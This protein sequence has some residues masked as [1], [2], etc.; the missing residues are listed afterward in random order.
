VSLAPLAPHGDMYMPRSLRLVLPAT[1]ALASVLLAAPVGAQDVT[2]SA[3]PS[4]TPTSAPQAAGTA[5]AL[6]PPQATPNPVAFETPTGDGTGVRLTTDLGDVVIG[7]FTESAPVASENFLNLVESGYYDGVGFHRVVPGF[8]IQGGDPEGTGAGGPGY[9]IADEEVVGEYGRGIVAMARTPEP[10]SQGS[11]FFIVLDDEAKRSLDAAGTY[12]I[13][14]RVVEGMDVVDAIV[15]RGPASDQIEDP[16]RIQKAAVEQVQLPPE[17]T[18]APPSA[19]EEV[20]AALAAKLPESVAGIDLLDR[21]A[22]DSTVVL[23]EADPALIAELEAVANE[24]GTDLE[25]LSIARASGA[26]EEA[27]AAVVAVTIPGTPA[28]DVQ[29]VLSRLIF[30][31]S[32][33]VIS[34]QE[35]IAGREVTRYE[36]TV[37]DGPAQIAYGLPSDEVAWFLVTDEGSLEEVIAALP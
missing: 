19:S 13:F 17:P 8:V 18:P 29:E 1:L 25:G 5:P 26:S 24:R 36:M 20:A 33:D 12:A 14:G 15:A 23:S 9:T 28:A 10:N 11:Q 34:T 21:A 6:A 7:L 22:F 2:P 27:F 3:V 4:A 31:V 32:D 35:V 30:G 37:E 16:V